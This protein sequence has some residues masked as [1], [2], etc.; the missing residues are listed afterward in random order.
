LKSLVFLGSIVFSLNLMAQDV[1][2]VGGKFL[3]EGKMPEGYEVYL[4]V[5]ERSTVKKDLLTIYP[6]Y[7]AEQGEESLIDFSP[8][9]HREFFRLNTNGA[10]IA[11]LFKTKDG[12]SGFC[13]MET[14][15][16]SLL[17]VDHDTIRALRKKHSLEVPPEQSIPIDVI[18]D[19]YRKGLPQTNLEV[20]CV[21]SKAGNEVNCEQCGEIMAFS[22]TATSLIVPKIRFIEED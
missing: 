7:E 22:L 12:T 11:G 10:H 3:G 14:Y 8:E 13:E 1:L 21:T 9:S 2:K 16:L 19:P 18:G 15:E 6:C 4:G 20:E 17:I 5:T